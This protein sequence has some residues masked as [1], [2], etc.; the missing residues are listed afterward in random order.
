[1]AHGQMLAYKKDIF[2]IEGE[3]MRQKRGEE[4]EFSENVFFFAPWVDVSFP[5]VPIQFNE[6]LLSNLQVYDSFK[7]FHC[8]SSEKLTFQVVKTLYL[9][10]SN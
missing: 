8:R 1:M 7:H 2:R 5:S 10:T 4:C 9:S 6:S 3:I